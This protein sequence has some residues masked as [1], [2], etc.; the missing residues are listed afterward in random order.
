ME[1]AGSKQKIGRH[2]E[3]FV[4]LFGEIESLRNRLT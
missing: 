2:L 3:M 4:L 1:V